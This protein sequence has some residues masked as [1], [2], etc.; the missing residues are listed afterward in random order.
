MWS[1][2]VRSVWVSSRWVL[3]GLVT[4]SKNCG[5]LGQVAW[6]LQPPADL[7]LQS[8]CTRAE[9]SRGSACVVYLHVRPTTAT[10]PLSIHSVFVPS[11]LRGSCSLH[12]HALFIPY[13]GPCWV[14]SMSFS[15]IVAIVFISSA[16]SS[17]G[18]V[19]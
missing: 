15:M 6:F 10:P 5:L 11:R 19:S 17:P 16:V 12:L 9:E 13:G 4:W 14:H 7:P 18:C 2:S 3:V 8:P 1:K